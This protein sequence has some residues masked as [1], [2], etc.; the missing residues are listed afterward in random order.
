LAEV[1]LTPAS[2][3]RLASHAKVDRRMAVTDRKCRGK[4]DDG[5]EQIP[6]SRGRPLAKDAPIERM[7]RPAQGARQIP[8]DQGL[9]R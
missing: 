3:L 6:D 2:E 1:G 4:I 9:K 5:Q 7:N 8:G